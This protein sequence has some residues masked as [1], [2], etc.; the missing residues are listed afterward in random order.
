MAKYSKVLLSGSTQ[1]K[2]IKIVATATAGTTVHQTGNPTTTLDEVWAWAYNS[3]T[4]DREITIEFGG[5]TS[6]DNTMKVTIPFKAGWIPILVGHLLTGTG[7]GANTIGIFAAA[8]NVI[9]VTG[10]V[11]RIT[12]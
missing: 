2:A 1:G 5:V 7:A 10:F 8:A 3:D 12:G 9:M 6:P 4:V 11:N